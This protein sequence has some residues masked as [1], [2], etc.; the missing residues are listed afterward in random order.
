MKSAWRK[1]LRM[2]APRYTS[3]PSAL[4]FDGSVCAA[5]Y[6]DRLRAVD[7]YDPL[8]IYIHIPFCK[9][10][11]WFCGC[12][13]RVENHRRRVSGY[14]DALAAEIGLVARALGGRGRPGSVHF[15]GGTPNFLS[16]EEIAAVLETVESELGLTDDARLAI[17]LDPRLIRDNDITGLADLGF[18]RMSL[19]VQDFDSSVQAAINRVQ[20]FELIESVVGEM[21][22]NGVED[23]AFDLLYGLPKQTLP[24]FSATLEK[25][26]ALC[27][28]R[29]AIFGYAHLPDALPRQRLIREEDLPDEQLRADLAFLADRALLAA[30][31]RRIGFDH[32]ARPGN[33]LA[34]AA[35]EGRV[36]RNFQGFTEDAAAAT[37]G[38]GASAISRI[39]DL[40]AQ[41]EKR[42]IEYCARI[43]A[44]QLATAR[45]LQLSP[46]EAATARAIHDLLCR[47]VADISS[48]LAATGP[49]DAA[50]ICANLD[51]LEADGLIEWR[52]DRVFINEDARL[53]SRIVARALDPYEWVPAQTDA[54]TTPA[55]AL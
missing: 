35:I 19:G 31:Y 4:H 42:P 30:G 38:I 11:C 55:H 5:D 54:A 3:Y 48:L 32:Y 7:L 51:A 22:R 47:G 28:D 50:A 6:E 15:G 44:D 14:V 12:T 29:I 18:A 53:L 9:Q 46:W 40:Y 10:L 52:D 34:R 36:R 21:R 2:R 33:R 16:V 49:H 41:N 45:G 20:S 24:G 39:G 17:E 27:P 43:A 37:I 25:A 1:Y 26:V 23:V 8:S 13:M